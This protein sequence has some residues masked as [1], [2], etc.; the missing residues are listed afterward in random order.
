MSVHVVVVAASLANQFATLIHSV[1]IPECKHTCVY[2][3]VN[4]ILEL[5]VNLL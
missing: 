5:H 2:V 1:A 3:Q 4:K